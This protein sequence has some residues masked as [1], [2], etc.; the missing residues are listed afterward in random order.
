MSGPHCPP[1][2]AHTCGPYH[3]AAV[4][5]SVRTLPCT[6]KACTP[7]L[8]SC[9]CADATHLPCWHPAPDDVSVPCCTASAVNTFGQTPPC[10]HMDVT[11]R[12]PP[13]LCFH[14]CMPPPHATTCHCCWHAP[15][16]AGSAATT[17]IK[18][19]S[20]H[21]R[22]LLSADQEH[23]RSFSTAGAYPRGA[24][25]QS[26]VL[27]VCPAGLKHESQEC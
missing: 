4:S 10:L 23:I 14:Q 25:E 15:V 3:P 6:G 13:V 7:T 8:L 26:P 2:L 9:P 21:P 27:G 24:R 1:L 16:N 11:T 17:P 20:W 18:H 5:V 12:S 22:V 19:F